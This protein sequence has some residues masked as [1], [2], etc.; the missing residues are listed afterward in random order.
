M[1]VLHPHDAGALDASGA[2]PVPPVAP[3]PPK[4]L[5]PYVPVRT[6]LRVLLPSLVLGWTADALFYRRALGVSV[7][8][9]VSLALLTLFLVA[10][11]ERVT[12]L[13]R[14]LWPIAPALFFAAM[15]AVHANPLLTFLNL[16][17]L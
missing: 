8:L 12:P 6:A 13:R 11:Q 10:R 5:I 16:F 1:A 2:L 17:A 15:V 3:L 7:P 14:N 4:P 9:F